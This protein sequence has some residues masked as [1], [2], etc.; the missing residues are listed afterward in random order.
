MKFLSA[1]KNCTISASKLIFL[2]VV[3]WIVFAN[4]SFL[5][6]LFTDYPLNTQ[7]A[8][9]LAVILFGFWGINVMVLLLFGWHKTLKPI[10][11]FL[12]LTS[13]FAAY[14]MD[15]YHVVIDRTMI[16]NALQTDMRETR[17]LLSFTTLI[18]FV[19]LGLLPSVVIWQINVSYLPFKKE[20]IKRLKVIGLILLV[21]ALSYALFSA[22]VSSFFREH[23]SIR[24][25]YNPTNYIFATGKYISKNIHSGKKQVERV[26]EDAVTPEADTDRELIILVV[27]ETARADRFSLNGYVKKTNPMLEKQRVVSFTNFTSCGTSTAVSVPCMFSID[28]GDHFDTGKARYKE[29]ALDVLAHAKVNVLWRDNNSSSKGVADRV[30]YEDFRDPEVNTICDEECRDEGMLVGLE[31]YIEK[32]PTGDILIVLHQMGNHGPAYYKRY[33]KEFEVF[34]PACQT[35][36]LGNCTVEEITNAYDNAILYTD[37]FLAKT[38]AFLKQYDDQFETGMLYVS[39]HGESLGENGIY[40]HGMPNFIAPEE[41]RHVPAIM[42]IG[43]NFDE[44]SYDLLKERANQPYTHDHIFHTILGLMEVESAVYNP[45]MNFLK[46][47]EYEQYER[48]EH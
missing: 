13:P 28:A 5:Q 38:I 18:Y 23:K 15:T 4:Q 48:E 34:T 16:E 27:G 36:E 33:P 43:K 42:W 31:E 10:L 19:L 44:I 24:F 17:D 2:I 26:G 20:A 47:E 1:L 35:Q 39:D 21:M 9:F 46:N 12:C 40:L 32:H 37:H 29:N 8:G 6:S 41:Q 45:K 22:T 30:E 11:I 7:N 14:F 25:Y 3:F